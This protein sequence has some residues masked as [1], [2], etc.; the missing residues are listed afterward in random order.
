MSHIAD[1][2]DELAASAADPYLPAELD[3]AED[4]L[5]DRERRTPNSAQWALLIDPTESLEH[6]EAAWNDALDDLASG[7]HGGRAA[8][9]RVRP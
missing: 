7:W 4:L 9:E 3:F 6:A 2:V 1:V 8:A 5:A